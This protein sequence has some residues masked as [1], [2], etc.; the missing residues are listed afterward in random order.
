MTEDRCLPSE[1]TIYTVGELRPQW[2]RW[3]A[4]EAE[5]ER[6]AL[7]AGA[8]AEVDAAGV[9]MLLSL[10]RSLASRRQGL[11]LTEPSRTLAEACKALGLA[12]LLSAAAPF[13]AHP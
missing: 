12:E 7:G 9:Q 2:L 10:Q 11:C 1:L 13:G 3:L 8:V 5:S 4:E 6:F